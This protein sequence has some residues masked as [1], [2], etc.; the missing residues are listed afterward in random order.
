MFALVRVEMSD[1]GVER[2]DIMMNFDDK[3]TAERVKSNY[4]GKCKMEV[5][6]L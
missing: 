2:Y 6:E 4:V 5:L 1:E 3:E